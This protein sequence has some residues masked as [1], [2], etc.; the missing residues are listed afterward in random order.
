MNDLKYD[1]NELYKYKYDFLIRAI[2][3]A[4]NIIRFTDTKAGAVIGF[5]GVIVT[6]SINKRDEWFLWLKNVEP[7]YERLIVYTLVFF[8][9]CFVVQSIWLAFMVL[10]PKNNPQKHIDTGEVY[11][12]GIFFLYE[13]NP[14]IKGKYLYT[15][16]QDL[17]LKIKTSDY[18]KKLKK[19]DFDDLQKELVI[20][21]QKVSFIRNLKIRRIDASISAIKSFII[22]FLI[23]LI[24]WLGYTFVSFEGGEALIELNIDIKLFIVLFIGHKIGDFLFP[25][26]RQA[27]NKSKE[28]VPLLSHSTVYTFIVLGLAYVFTGFFNWLAIIVLFISHLILDNRKFLNW[29]AKHIK[30]VTDYNE[31]NVVVMRIDQAFHYIILFIVSLL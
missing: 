8:M 6:I 4:Q 18:I 21:L 10:I 1:A 5:W 14:D 7:F 29:W 11:A 20:E 28:L 15:T 26:E 13:T 3:D 12:E 17:K 31:L 30:G 2:E 23:I 25:T 16:Q 19:I 9:V 24:Y 27:T 22:G